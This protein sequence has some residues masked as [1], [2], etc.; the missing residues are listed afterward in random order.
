ML[1]NKLSFETVFIVFSR[2]LIQNELTQ[3]DALPNV[4]ARV[5]LQLRNITIFWH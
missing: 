5:P 3:R 4:N 1:K 2:N